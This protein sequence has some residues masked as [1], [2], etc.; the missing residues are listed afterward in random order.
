MQTRTLLLLA[1]LALALA[2]CPS[3]SQQRAMDAVA[4]FERCDIRAANE[5]FAD[6]RAMD[7]GQPDIALGFAL[8][9]LALLVEDPALQTL[10]PRVGFTS[11]LDTSFLWGRG[12]ALEQL[13]DESASCSSI[14]EFI[15]DQLPHP[16]AHDGGP[17]L[18]E[19]WDPTLTVG[20]VRVAALALLP[21]LERIELAL[22]TAATG[23]SD[24]GVVLE[25]G[26]GVA[27]LPTRLQAPELLAL[28]AA[29]ATVRAGIEA[30]QAYDGELNAKLLFSSGD[31][32]AA[33]VA[34]MN[35]H[36][37]RPTD[38]AAL[39]TARAT[40]RHAIEL[41][42]QAVDAA[43]RVGERRSD[44]VFDWTAMPAHVLA[45]LRVMGAAG[46]ASLDTGAT[47]IPFVEPVLS[48]DAASFFT[49]PF[50]L[51][52]SIWS[53]GTS[54]DGSYQWIDADGAEIERRLDARFSPS[55]WA[56]GTSYRWQLSD[57]WDGTPWEE[58]FDPSD[59][60]SSAYSCS[61][62]TTF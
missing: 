45:D 57:R 5:A 21:R 50:R 44:A 36:A 13:A 8:T 3:A 60:W 41:A 51:D 33:W 40:L 29:L 12:G 25:G 61:S 19:T 52:G 6:A 62:T 31:D 34:M 28:A 35:G 32:E 11:A 47:P 2:G 53:V 54:S 15:R 42:L 59:R 16:A 48:F 27:A 49:D 14:G 43:G 17:S 10:A 26:C 1:V 18:L 20:D 22:V 39:A 58:I 56:T 30:T 9:E 24:E 37:L 7:S 46:I 38:P 23:M 4:A 55:P